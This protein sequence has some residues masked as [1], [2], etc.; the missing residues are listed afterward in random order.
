MAMLCSEMITG[1]HN[2]GHN[3]PGFCLGERGREGAERCPWTR[4]HL[5][6]RE[7]KGV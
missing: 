6:L 3:V 5:A 4:L 1:L 7:R 2:E